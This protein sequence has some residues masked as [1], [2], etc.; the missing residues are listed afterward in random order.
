L[1]RFLLSKD[2]TD[3]KTVAAALRALGDFPQLAADPA[4]QAY[5]S[6]ALQS[7]ENE[8][9]RAAVQLVLNAPA[10]R[11]VPAVAA[12][13]DGIFKSE[14]AAR[15]KLVLDLVMP[16]AQVENDLRLVGLVADALE[17]L[18]KTS[19]LPRSTP[20]AASSA[21]KHRRDSR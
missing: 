6:A 4:V 3:K 7:S 14:S 11:A 2:N 15:R 16:E 9:L 17:A 18:K 12:A 19:V 5:L 8:L 20:C 10:V 13:L 21:A 1:R